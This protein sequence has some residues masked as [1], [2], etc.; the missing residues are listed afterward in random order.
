MYSGWITQRHT[1]NWLGAH[2]KFNKMAYRQ[3]APY[4]HMHWFPPLDRLQ[5][6]EGYNGP[7][8]IK[9]KTIHRHEEPSHFYDPT[10]QSGPLLDDIENHYQ[11]LAGALSEQNMVRAAFEAA[12]LA[13]TVTDG[14]TPAHHIS[15]EES[16]NEMYRNG[17]HTFRK[18]RHKV[19][20][21]GE[22]KLQTLQQNWQ[23]WGGSGLLSMH[24]H[25]ELGVAA[26]V[27][28]SNI[29]G[30]VKPAKLKTARKQGPAG[31]FQ[32]R[33]R[34]IHRLHMY[35]RFGQ[36]SWTTEL[37]RTVRRRLAPAIVQAI[38]VEW[39]LAAEEAGVARR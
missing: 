1:V 21:Q 24:I 18:P 35:E 31:F 17:N 22:T 25:F 11:S 3:L 32:A 13:H 10:S 6:F 14:L 16:L 39:I 33:A 5:H 2:Q 23:M 19:I 7:D 36:Q 15:Y 37:A 34:D 4:V 30:E 8:G 20:M 27:I 26:A 38:A 12:W 28:A 29:R 9:V